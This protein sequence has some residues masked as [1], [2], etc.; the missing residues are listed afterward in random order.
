[1]AGGGGGN[2]PKTGIAI[3]GS[4]SFYGGTLSTDKLLELL[5][6]SDHSDPNTFRELL[7]ESIETGFVSE[8]ELAK[9]LGVHPSLVTDWRKGLV[10]PQG[11]MLRRVILTYCRNLVMAHLTADRFGP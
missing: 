5:H 6:K 11:M 2:R 8:H 9:F 4:R 1:M 10:E 7:R 3:E